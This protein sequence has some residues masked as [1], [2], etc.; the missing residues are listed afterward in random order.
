ML[1]SVCTG[2]LSCHPGGVFLV[3]FRGPGPSTPEG[4][5]GKHR[6]RSQLKTLRPAPDACPPTV[7]CWCCPSG[8]RHRMHRNIAHLALAGRPRSPIGTLIIIVK[9]QN[10]HMH[11]CTRAHAHLKARGESPCSPGS[12][13]ALHLHLP[14]APLPRCVYQALASCCGICCSRSPRCRRHSLGTDAVAPAT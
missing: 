13:P 3:F 2:M 12:H 10:T 4:R 5:G 8:A 1:S 14:R 11:T 6:P 7:H 9:N